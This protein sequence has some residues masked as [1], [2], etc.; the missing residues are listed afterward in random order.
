MSIEKM[1]FVT[2]AGP[3]KDLDKALCISYD[4]QAFNL[5]LDKE[6][7]IN[8]NPVRN[9]NNPY[10]K[11]ISEALRISE[12]LNLKIERKYKNPKISDI[13]STEEYINNLGKTYDSVTEKIAQNK[14]FITE[15]E[16]IYKLI[17]HLAG[18]EVDFEDIFK[19][20]MISIRFGRMPVDSVP[21]LEYYSK[22]DF[23]YISFDEDEDWSWGVY[24]TS[25]AKKQVTD[26]VFDSLYFERTHIP[27]FLK[28]N[29]SDSINLLQKMLAEEREKLAS[30]Q[31]KLKE[32]TI[33]NKTKLADAYALLRKMA[34]THEISDAAEIIGKSYYL[35]GYVPTR[36]LNWFINKFDKLE[37]TVVTMQAQNNENEP[38]PEAEE[39]SPPVLLK[40]NR[41]IKPFEMFVN[42]YG[43]PSYDGIDPTGYFAISYI[44]LYGIMFG[45][46]GQGLV[47]ALLGFIL[48]DKF[49][50][51]PIM[52]RIG[53]SSAFFGIIYGSVF[54]FETIITPFFHHEVIYKF[55]GYDSPPENLFQIA[56]VLII[57]ALF[58]GVFLILTTM[59]V[60]IGVSIKR[61][62]WGNA[63]F[64]A[65]GLAGFIL[66]A[67]I[68]ALAGLQLGLG[69]KVASPLYIIL[70]I[71]LPLVVIFM[72]EPL[73]KLVTK[74]KNFDEEKQSVGSFIG[75]GFI[76]MF[77]VGLTY[78]SN[79]MSF[80]RVGGFI[81]SHA[82]MMLVVAQF[83]GMNAPDPKIGVGTIIAYV[84]GN[85][86][87][88]FIEGFLVGI[89][90]LRLEFYEI[91]SRF[92]V[93]G[94]KQ[95]IPL[96]NDF[97]I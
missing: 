88:I 19:C 60:N 63:F 90:V 4:T 28:G 69:I 30:A 52:S 54:G 18:L 76:E 27:E 37:E 24:F 29:A 89:Q 44:L 66:Y 45:D 31:N 70:L 73:T 15:H 50:L 21:K 48:K 82:G 86:I 77:E 58:I 25:K 14:D 35:S 41:V 57:F 75:M 51:A 7:M 33:Q 49:P 79:T 92:Y 8:K 6:G 97:E 84:L 47:I 39:N 67:S 93:A 36:K 64:G 34:I 3:T 95:F 10:G 81:L 74:E 22:K 83:G 94:G 65:N 87:V 78:L 23:V 68:I 62:S 42:M 16:N 12:G 46:L 11:L 53:F 2:I 1:S 32:L 56:N 43:L 96:G 26:S 38:S 72:R 9:D 40:N 13:G 55:L 17:K 71:I 5:I 61:K 85:A 20:K 59:A 80:L 91:F